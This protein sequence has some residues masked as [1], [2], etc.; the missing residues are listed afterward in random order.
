MNT[1]RTSG[2]ELLCASI[3]C[4]SCKA[5]RT[6][7]QVMHNR[8]AKQSKDVSDEIDTIS[9]VNDQY[10]NTPQKKASID[11]LRNRVHI[12]EEEI[13]RLEE[14]VHKL[15]TQGSRHRFRNRFDPHCE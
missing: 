8:W 6:N 10:L 4:V 11:A 14:K 7:L 13:K 9:Y 15:S 1:I 5:Y 2:Y 12:A 3:K